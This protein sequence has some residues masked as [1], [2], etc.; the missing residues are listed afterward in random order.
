[1][2]DLEL[3][4]GLADG[5]LDKEQRTEA[6]ARMRTNPALAEQYEDILLLRRA[7]KKDCPGVRNDIAWEATRSRLAELDRNK[8]VELFTG[9]YAWQMAA[10]LFFVLVGVGFYNRSA[11]ARPLHMAELAGVTNQLNAAPFSMSGILDFFTKRGVD[12]Q[13]EELRVQRVMK[14][15]FDGREI[16]LLDLSD[17]HGPLRLIAVADAGPVE[18]TWNGTSNLR[19]GQLGQ[20]RCVT[21]NQNGNALLLVGDRSNDELA[22]IAASIQNR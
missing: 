16:T 1:M 11:G 21:W 14:G 9:R 5:S 4:H 18:G 8:T 3:I 13:R 20:L 6:E 15:Q 22:E 10:C 2:N 12:L 17:S 19:Y 7:L